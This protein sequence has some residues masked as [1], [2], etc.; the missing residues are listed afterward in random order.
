VIFFLSPKD[1]L[2]YFFCYQRRCHYRLHAL[3]LRAF[4]FFLGGGLSFCRRSQQQ[5][6]YSYFIMHNVIIIRNE[7]KTLSL[8]CWQKQ[9]KDILALTLEMALEV[10][11]SYRV[12][13]AL[14]SSLKFVL[15]YFHLFSVDHVSLFLIERARQILKHNKKSADFHAS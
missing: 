7:R 9:P 3:E 1:L 12:S 10:H 4:F 15:I 8:K 13:P 2:F 5:Q 6:Q 14:L 11:R